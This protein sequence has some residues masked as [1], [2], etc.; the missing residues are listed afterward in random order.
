MTWYRCP[1]G[2]LSSSGLSEDH[3]DYA[4]LDSKS[5]NNLFLLLKAVV[6]T[7]QALGEKYPS[8]IIS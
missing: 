8:V 7:I 5:N 6:Q 2:S 4:K 1:C 3:V